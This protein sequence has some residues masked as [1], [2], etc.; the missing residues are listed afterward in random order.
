MAHRQKNEVHVSTARERFR[1][2]LARPACTPAA[3]ATSVKVPSPLLR[4]RKFAPKFVTYRSRRPSP[5]KSPAHTPLPQAA[6]STPASRA[7]FLNLQL[8]RLR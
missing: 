1:Q 3:R 6:A 2:I 7:T 4:N 8:P 5:L